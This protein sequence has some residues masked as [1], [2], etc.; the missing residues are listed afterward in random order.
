MKEMNKL[1]NSFGLP[2]ECKMLCESLQYWQEEIEALSS[3]ETIQVGPRDRSLY[4]VRNAQRS[5]LL[6]SVRSR[7]NVHVAVPDPTQRRAF[8]QAH[9]GRPWI[10]LSNSCGSLAKSLGSF[11]FTMYYI[12]GLQSLRCVE[13]ARQLVQNLSVRVSRVLEVVILVETQMGQRRFQRLFVTR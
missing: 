2:E 5:T 12:S 11:S 1:Q 6:R 13:A 7:Q 10:G 3:G 8:S 4:V 9:N